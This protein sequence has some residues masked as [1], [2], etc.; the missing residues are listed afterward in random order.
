MISHIEYF[1]LNRYL[2]GKTDERVAVL[3]SG[4]PEIP[5]PKL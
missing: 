2:T 3:K 5:F 4:K 1:F